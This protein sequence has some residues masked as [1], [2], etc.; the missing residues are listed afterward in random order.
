M[1][2]RESAC[3][4]RLRAMTSTNCI[5]VGSWRRR[6]VARRRPVPPKP[7]G[8]S[9]DPYKAGAVADSIPVRPWIDHPAA[10]MVGSRRDDGSSHPSS[11]GATAADAGRAEPRRLPNLHAP[12]KRPRAPCRSIP[13]PTPPSAGSLS[14]PGVGRPAPLGRRRDGARRPP[15]HAPDRRPGAGPARRHHRRARRAA[16]RPPGRH[17]AR[18]RRRERRRLARAAAAAGPPARGS[19]GR[20]RHPP[21][22]DGHRPRPLRDPGDRLR[23]G[24][25]RA[26]AAAT[27]PTWDRV[28]ANC[29]KGES[30]ELDDTVID[31]AARRRSDRATSFG[32]LLDRLQTIAPKPTARA[33][34]RASAALMQPAAGHARGRRGS[35]KPGGADEVLTTVAAPR[36]TCRPTC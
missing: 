2:S 23:R 9:A 6:P 33:S 29:L 35:G 26:R 28:L 34:A 31:I 32:A 36:R 30:V 5:G 4:S 12:A 14:P 8:R 18:P 1:A 10:R 22:M 3:P 16:A 20:R 24:A 19:A 17:A 13:A 21:G 27:A 25:A 7:E 15:D 11:A